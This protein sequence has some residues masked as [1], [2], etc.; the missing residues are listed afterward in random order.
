MSTWLVVWFIVAIVSTAAVTACL[1]ALVR[2]VLILGRSAR[3]LQDAVKP[4]ADG[5]AAD[6]DR[7]SM[8]AASMQVPGRRAS[9]G[10]G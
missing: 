6:G 4:L 3:E 5:I 1:I 7:A 9:S 2:H 8:R 10:R